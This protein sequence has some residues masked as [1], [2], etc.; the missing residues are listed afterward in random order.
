MLIWEKNLNGI[1]NTIQTNQVKPPV[2]N[3]QVGG[4]IHAEGDFTQQCC[5]LSCMQNIVYLSVIKPPS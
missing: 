5:S 1:K 3:L 4:A 2:P